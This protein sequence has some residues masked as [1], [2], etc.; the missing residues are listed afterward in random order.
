MFSSRSKY[1]LL[2]NIMLLVGYMS[3]SVSATSK[4]KNFAD[5]QPWHALFKFWL[6]TKPSG[7][8][9]YSSFVGPWPP[10]IMSLPTVWWVMITH[11]HRSGSQQFA[12][13]LNLVTRRCPINHD[14]RTCTCIVNVSAVTVPVPHMY[15]YQWIECKSECCLYNYNILSCPN[16][17]SVDDLVLTYTTIAH[18]RTLTI[19]AKLCVKFSSLFRW[20]CESFHVCLCVCVCVCAYM[21]L[22]LCVYVCACMCVC[23]WIHTFPLSTPYLRASWYFYALVFGLSLR[24]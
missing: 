5:D 11:A 12:C 8:Y 7:C 23:V 17:T 16:H 19:S 6:C 1:V 9:F 3:S 22:C 21:C 18:F 10:F 4:L 15:V 20:L 13:K 2:N 14:T 24:S